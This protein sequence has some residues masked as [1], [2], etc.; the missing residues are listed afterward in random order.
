[1]AIWCCA[2]KL[3]K[4]AKTP[5]PVYEHGFK[6]SWKGEEYTLL[7]FK[8]QSFIWCKNLGEQVSWGRYK[9][10]KNAWRLCSFMSSSEDVPL[11][12]KER[13]D[14]NIEGIVIQSHGWNNPT[15]TGAWQGFGI[16]K[17]SVDGDTCM[18]WL[19]AA[20]DADN[21]LVDTCEKRVQ[22]SITLH[23][24]GSRAIN[25]SIASVDNNVFD[26]YF[27]QFK[28]EAFQ[29]FTPQV[30]QLSKQQLHFPAAVLKGQEASKELLVFERIKQVSSNSTMQVH[31][32]GTA[33]AAYYAFSGAGRSIL[34][35]QIEF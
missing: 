6:A 25:Y 3:T 33:L 27:L 28:P 14:P 2:C 15:F 1:M 26:C 20:L 31:T 11:V 9:E 29:V 35:E 5:S 13:Y 10:E 24:W 34:L 12:V 22:A 18:H 23:H 17:A 21:T 4:E 16:T 19:V 30:A 8:D 32:E 7:L